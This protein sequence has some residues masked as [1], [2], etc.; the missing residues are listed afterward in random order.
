[1]PESLLSIE[2][3][4]EWVGKTPRAIYDLR[5]RGEL[6]A[7]PLSIEVGGSVRYDPKDVREWLNEQKEQ[8]RRELS[9]RSSAIEATGLRNRA[10]PHQPVGKRVRVQVSPPVKENM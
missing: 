6:G 4:A 1:M 9:D 10:R 2:E 8:S 5:Y 3:L 7:L